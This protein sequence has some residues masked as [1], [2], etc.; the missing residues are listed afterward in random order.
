MKEKK[1]SSNKRFIIILLIIFLLILLIGGFLL[2]K[3]LRKEPAEEPTS[4]KEIPYAVDVGLITSGTTFDDIREDADKV[5]PLSYSPYLVSSDGINFDCNIGNPLGAVYDMY[6]DFYTDLTFEHQI[7]LTGLVP[8]GSKLQKIT[9]NI[10]F[11]EGQRDIIMVVTTV[12]DDHS[13]LIAQQNIV[14][15]ITVGEQ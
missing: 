10:Q 14:L 13:T 7:Y 12:A 6:F 8:P 15:T 1:Q 5:I 4:K 3:F 11:P 9:S 2:L